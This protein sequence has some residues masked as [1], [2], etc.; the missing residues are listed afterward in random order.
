MMVKFGVAVWNATWR[1]NGRSDLARM[2]RVLEYR[3]TYED[4]AH[5]VRVHASGSPDLI[6]RR[7]LGVC[8]QWDTKP[9]WRGKV[10]SRRR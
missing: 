1:V 5:A 6:G 3:G 10:L 2:N 8:S 4:R 9:R 7:E